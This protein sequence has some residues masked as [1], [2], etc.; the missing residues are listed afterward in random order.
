MKIWHEELFD[1]Y[2]NVKIGSQDNERNMHGYS[3]QKNPKSHFLGFMFL[4]KISRFVN[5]K[6]LCPIFSKNRVIEV[7]I[8]GEKCDNHC[9]KC[10]NNHQ[11]KYIIFK[12]ENH[13]DKKDIAQKAGKMANSVL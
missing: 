8:K 5:F 4:F 6:A 3:F 7:K 1:S 12:I 10:S 2:L 13:G 11:S 9:G